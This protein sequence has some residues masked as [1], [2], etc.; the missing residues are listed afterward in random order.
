MVSATEG[1]EC[2]VATSRF[3]LLKIYILLL[4]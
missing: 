2:V 3:K 4:V 1:A